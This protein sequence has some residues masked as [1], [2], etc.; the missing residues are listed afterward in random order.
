MNRMPFA[1]AKARIIRLNEGGTLLDHPNE[2]LTIEDLRTVKDSLLYTRQQYDFLCAI[3]NFA[4][5]TAPKDADRYRK[6]RSA[7]RRLHRNAERL[8]NEI[9]SQPPTLF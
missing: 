8:L 6:H 4:S 2:K 7:Y 9:E 3:Q 5:I 1:E